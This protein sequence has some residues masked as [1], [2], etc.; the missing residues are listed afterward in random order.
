MVLLS[1]AR[2]KSA[3]RRLISSQSAAM[4]NLSYSPGG[5]TATVCV[6]WRVVG[7]RCIVGRVLTTDK[8]TAEKE[9]H[10]HDE[11]SGPQKGKGTQGHDDSGDTERTHSAKQVRK[12]YTDCQSRRPTYASATSTKEVEN[13]LAKPLPSPC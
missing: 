9:E 2:W 10:E 11:Q 8:M 13:V 7:A 3:A 4:V 5:E 6:L 1:C 12:H